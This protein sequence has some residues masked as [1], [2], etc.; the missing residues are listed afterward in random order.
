MG[1]KEKKGRRKATKTREKKPG[2]GESKKQK[3]EVGWGTRNRG[4]EERVILKNG[5]G[6]KGD[7]V[8]YPFHQKKD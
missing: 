6:I 4:G 5:V 1:K 2:G 8:G 7:L 3:K